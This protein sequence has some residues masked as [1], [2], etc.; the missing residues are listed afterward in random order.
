[1][2]VCSSPLSEDST[3]YQ[4][5]TRLCSALAAQVIFGLLRDSRGAKPSLGRSPRAHRWSRIALDHVESLAVARRL[6][7]AAAYSR[8]RGINVLAKRPPP[9]QIRIRIKQVLYNL[10]SNAMMM[11]TP[12]RGKP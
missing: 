2:R 5:C 10:L 9:G 4:T 7:L 8:I 1:M 12:D 3:T 11:F 6:G